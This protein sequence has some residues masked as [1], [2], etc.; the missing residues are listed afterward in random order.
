VSYR[1]GTGISWVLP[2]L[3]LLPPAANL[4]WDLWR[5]RSRV[6][7]DASGRSGPG[8]A[9]GQE[10]I[11]AAAA[12]NAAARQRIHDLEGELRALRFW[13]A[14][15]D[16]RYAPLH[17]RVLRLSDPS[18]RRSSFWIW[19]PS[20]EGVTV[21]TPVVHPASQVLVGRVERIAP[22]GI[23]RVQTVF[24]PFF[25][26]RFR[27]LPPPGTPAD[28]TPLEAWGFLSGTGQTDPKHHPILQIRHPGAD[29]PYKGEEMVVTDGDDGHFPGGIQIGEMVRTPDGEGFE[30]RSFVV[31]A[32]ISDAIL[33]VDR[34]A[35]R[36]A[37][38]E[39]ERKARR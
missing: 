15:A 31:L 8:P 36:A 12:E 26:V 38:E 35:F 19:A 24:D 13:S 21:R 27:I 17:A 34:A 25:R 4:A 11:L 6:D 14:A 29:L 18:P 7:A 10:E 39:A 23:A 3:L 33:L 28:S 37:A 9:G 1:K 30:V 32:E 2:L 20:L 5:G 16:D 22:G